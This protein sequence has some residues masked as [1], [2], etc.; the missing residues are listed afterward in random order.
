MKELLHTL[1]RLHS[2]LDKL[3]GKLEQ[4]A[5][6]VSSVAFALAQVEATLTAS[7]PAESLPSVRSVRAGEENEQ[8]LRELAESGVV[9]LEINHHNDGSA[10]VRIGCGKW[11]ALPP[12]LADLLEIL[13][14]SGGTPAAGHVVP[15]KA[16]DAVQSILASTAGRDVSQHAVAQLLSRLRKRLHAAGVN[17]WLVQRNRDNAMRF[18]LVMDAD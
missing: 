10:T 18:A 17:P 5:D 11:F 1:Q 4:I 15:W 2:E 8:L 13:A 3:T 7:T 12:M 14:D 9:G 16:P 6:R